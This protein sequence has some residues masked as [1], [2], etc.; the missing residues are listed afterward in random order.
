MDITTKI[1]A[2]SS[3]TTG[4]TFSLS[5]LLLRLTSKESLLVSIVAGLCAALAEF[6][7][8][9]ADREVREEMEYLAE[10]TQE[11]KDE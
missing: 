6:F 10:V 5:Y 3:I 2:A 11:T 8:A 9:T 1:G 7:V 4:L